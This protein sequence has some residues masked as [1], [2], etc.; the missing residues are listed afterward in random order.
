MPDTPVAT[1][2]DTDIGDDI[3][4]A[5]ALSVC[6]RH[7]EIDLVGVTTVHRDTEL[8]A[9]QARLLLELA[10]RS[11]VPV[12]AGSRDG[13]DRL[14]ELVRN[15]QADVLSAEDEA[16]LRKGRVDGVR[17]L[18]ERIEANPGCTLLPV[19]PF[20]NIGRLIVEFPEAFAKVGR[21][22]LMGGHVMP[23]REG[24][25]Y[26][27]SVD[28]RA[29]R[30][31]FTS[32][33]PVTIIGLD[34]TLRCVMTHEELDEIEAKDT[35]LSRAIMTMTRLWQQHVSPP[36][37]PVRTPCIHDPL[38]ALVSV[39]P[40]CVRLEKM[41]IDIDEEGRCLPGAGEPNAEVAVDVDPDA[42]RRRIVELIG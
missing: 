23:D 37:G 19:G 39:E 29:T 20:T 3:D 30:L 9:A 18:A 36:G 4:D 13:M 11:E 2:Y 26:N 10:G 12:A 22:V 16:R 8:R 32:G 41:H 42:V 5:W 34:V 7:P 31:T 15:N 28:P 6:I 25:E 1:L 33:K 17:F 27:A 21:I 14:F 24:P 40:A 38:A 35:P